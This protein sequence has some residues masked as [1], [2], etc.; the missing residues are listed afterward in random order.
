[1]RTTQGSREYFVV[2]MYT[3][4]L[5]KGIRLA[6]EIHGDKA[7]DEK[8]HRNLGQENLLQET[9]D[10]FA[11]S[12]VQ[13]LNSLVVVSIGG[14]QKFRSIVIEY[15]PEFNLIGQEEFDDTFGII[16][17]NGQQKF[18]AIKGQE[19]LLAMKVLLDRENECFSSV[20]E[21]FEN[22]EIPIIMFVFGDKDEKSMESCKQIHS[23]MK[24]LDALTQ[25]VDEFF[26]SSDQPSKIAV[27]DEESPDINLVRDSKS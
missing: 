25:F 5:V 1:M 20:P 2:K 3:K 6:Y 8:I 26:E 19:E 9:V 17:F 13:I 12:K 24:R 23:D 15:N 22:E 10:L 27:A 11:Q 7:L 14:D 21:D 18:Y 4:E 16:S